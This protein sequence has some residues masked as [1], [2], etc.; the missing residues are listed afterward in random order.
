M[1]KKKKKRLILKESFTYLSLG[2][3]N[4]YLEYA[5]I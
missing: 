3:S 4:M 5:L 1:R 2:S